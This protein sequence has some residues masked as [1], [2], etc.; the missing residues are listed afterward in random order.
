MTTTQT[1]IKNNAN[2]PYIE[3]SFDTNF[4]KIDSVTD[5]DFPYFS[6]L[7]AK[8]N[9][10]D[11]TCETCAVELNLTTPFYTVDHSASFC[12]SHLPTELLNETTL[13]F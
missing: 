10:T 12:L 7:I 2:D 6:I 9:N 13:N 11:I 3:L 5:F 4:T 8:T 1:N